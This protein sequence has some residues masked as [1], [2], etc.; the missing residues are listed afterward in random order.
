MGEVAVGGVSG[1]TDALSAFSV[2][3]GLPSFRLSPNGTRNK[4]ERARLAKAARD[5]AANACQVIPSHQRP[6]WPRGMVLVTATIVLPKGQ[7]QLDQDGAI[8]LLKSSVDGCQ[9]F[10][11]GNDRQ[12]EWAPIAWDRDPKLRA[13]IVRLTFEEVRE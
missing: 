1:V 3:V 13:G 6:L 5:E 12:L 7:R 11:L 10:V 8:G 9:G 4:Y 2:V